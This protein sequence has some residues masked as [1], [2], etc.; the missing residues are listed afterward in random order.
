MVPL[1]VG[2]RCVLLPH[3][4]VGLKVGVGY[5]YVWETEGHIGLDGLY[6]ALG[7]KI[8]LKHIYMDYKYHKLKKKYRALYNR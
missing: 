2:V 1:G 5:R 6:F 3:K 8:D 4:W 7:I